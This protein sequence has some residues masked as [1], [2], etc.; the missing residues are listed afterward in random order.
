MLKQFQAGPTVGSAFLVATR[1]AGL[2]Y[3]YEVD[4]WSVAGFYDLTFSFNEGTRLVHSLRVEQLE[5]DY[6]QSA[7]GG[8]HSR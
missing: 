5:Y 1:P 7:P 2:H 3:D 6:G 8:Q 4:G